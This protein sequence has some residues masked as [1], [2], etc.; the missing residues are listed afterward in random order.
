MI[1]RHTALVLLY[2]AL[3]AVSSPAQAQP[4]S[5][6]SGQAYPTRPVRL[7]VPISAGGGLDTIARAVG[8]KAT[9]SLGQTIVVDNRGGASGTIAAEAAKFAA[10]D[11]YRSS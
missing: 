9:E 5:T 8:Q 4:A 10:P 3:A 7:I 1:V 11:G 6:G 2:A